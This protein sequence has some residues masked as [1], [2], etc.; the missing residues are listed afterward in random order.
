MGG[1]GQKRRE[2]N[3]LKSHG[4]DKRLPPPPEM[5]SIHAIPSKLR[6]LMSY[7]SSLG[8]EANLESAIQLK[9]KKRDAS[10]NKPQSVV[11]NEPKSASISAKIEKMSAML[12]SEEKINPGVDDD[13]KKKKK[14]KRREV[15]DL[16][17]AAEMEKLGVTSKRKQRKKEFLK[18]KKKN[19][20]KGGP[21]QTLDL[22]KRDEVKFGDVVQ[23][24]PKLDVVPKAPKK[25]MNA[26]QERLRLQAIEAYRNRRGNNRLGIQL[27][28]LNP[29][30]EEQ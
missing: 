3:Y 18:N 14:R 15:N 2:K 28:S 20:K 26:S 17:F 24:P 25:P 19:Q 1:K 5:S 9:G 12:E 7:S 22:P 13:K 11:E 30:S 29:S 16:R 10:Q 21:E 27:P 4:G 6:K 23:A 8:N